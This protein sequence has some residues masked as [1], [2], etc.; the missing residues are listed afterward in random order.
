ML[1]TGGNLFILRCL[2][3]GELHK[4]DHC[5]NISFVFCAVVCWSYTFT[6]LSSVSNKTSQICSRCRLLC[7]YSAIKL[8]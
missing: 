7:R 6:L 1:D 2:G 4:Y 3:G 8:N 5:F